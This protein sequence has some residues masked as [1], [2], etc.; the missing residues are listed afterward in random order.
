MS[1]NRV[2]YVDWLRISAVISVVVYHALLPFGSLLPWSVQNVERSDALALL[3]ALLPFAFPVFFLLAGASARFAL[4]TRSVRN[5]LTERTA[6][7]LVPLVV[8]TLV[9]TPVTGYI[10]AL[11]AGTWSGS[12]PSY[13]AAYP[14]MV[15]DYGIKTFG[16]RPLLFQAVTMHLWFLGWLFLFCL[17]ASPLFAFLS[18]PRGRLHVDRLARAARWR[19]ASLLMAVPITLIALPLFGVSSPA[20]WDWAAFGLWGATFVAGYVMFSDER[21]IAAARRDL[22]PALVAAVLGVSGLAA[23]GFTDSIFLGGAHTYDATY[24][25]VVSVHGLAAWGVTLSVL[26][27][28]LHI[29]FMQRPL[30]RAANEAVLPTYVLHL[31][32]VIAIS[33]VVVQWPLGLVPKA[34]INVI[35]G[36]GVSLL[37]A[38]VALRL[39]VIRVLLGA[40]PRPVTTSVPALRTSTR[41]A[42]S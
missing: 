19:G 33:I 40:R 30:A 36:V 18:T 41:T 27:A 5:F 10:I 34:V 15:L 24:L 13:L 42:E 11:H 26:S 39:P 20:G 3:S 32:I 21:L 9:V 37:A 35:L 28:A 12:F 17:L 23:T 22:L 14:A 29:R 38:A 7:L 1:A 2:H 4:Q 6:R 25:L 16:F 8:G 31:P